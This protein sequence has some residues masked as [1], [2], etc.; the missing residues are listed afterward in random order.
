MHK[1]RRWIYT[2]HSRSSKFRSIKRS[3]LFQPCIQC[4]IFFTTSRQVVL[5]IATIFPHSH[6]SSLTK[7]IFQKCHLNMQLPCSI[8][9]HKRISSLVCLASK[10]FCFWREVLL[11]LLYNTN[12]WLIRQAFTSAMFIPIPGFYCWPPA[13]YLFQPST[14]LEIQLECHRWLSLTWWH[15]RKN[16]ALESNSQKPLCVPDIHFLHL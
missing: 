7:E 4:N 5:L 15:S 8:I 1:Y 11:I 9:Y 10:T 12:L 6:P 16:T 3:F 2:T 13:F 14:F